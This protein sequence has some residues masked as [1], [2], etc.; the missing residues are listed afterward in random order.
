MGASKMMIRKAIAG[1]EGLDHRA[2]W[3]VFQAPVLLA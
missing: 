2:A 3:N 1:E